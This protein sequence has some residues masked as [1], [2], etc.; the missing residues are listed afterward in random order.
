MSK[1]NNLKI[2][3]ILVLLK[4]NKTRFKITKKLKQNI[5]I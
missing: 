4:I 1:E 5:I 3:R 2:Y